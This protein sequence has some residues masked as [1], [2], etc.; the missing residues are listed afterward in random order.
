[1]MWC[2][3]TCSSP[4]S[5]LDHLQFHSPPPTQHGYVDCYC[6]Q[7]HW[8]HL[9]KTMNTK[10]TNESFCLSIQLNIPPFFFW[11]HSGPLTSSQSI[12]QSINQCNQQCRRCKRQPTRFIVLEVFS[13][14]TRRHRSHIGHEPLEY[15]FITTGRHISI[16]TADGTNTRGIEAAGSILINM[17]MR[18]MLLSQLFPWSTITRSTIKW[19]CISCELIYIIA[20]SRH[21]CP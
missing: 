15:R 2:Q 3:P 11:A 9:C 8:R 18:A 14:D 12:S 21:L 20:F 19:D 4:T 5:S 7:G 1:M 13:I 6:S 16:S 10:L 17:E